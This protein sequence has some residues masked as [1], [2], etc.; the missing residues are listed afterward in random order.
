MSQLPAPLAASLP[1]LPRWVRGLGVQLPL[2]A[3]SLIRSF[4]D[5]Q[6]GI[7]NP[8]PETAAK[9][10]ATTAILSTSF[11]GGE[12]PGN[13]QPRALGMRPPTGP[14]RMAMLGRGAPPWLPWVC[15]ASWWIRASAGGPGPRNIRA[16]L[17]AAHRHPAHHPL[18]TSCPPSPWPRALG[19]PPRGNG[20]PPA[21]RPAKNRDLGAGRGVKGD[22]ELLLSIAR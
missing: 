14:A 20:Q 10:T 2:A 16:G 21:A 19:P 7:T 1:A 4:S 17:C 8:H 13:K 11:R 12:R 6:T 5:W 9:T 18:P 3:D 15:F 22:G